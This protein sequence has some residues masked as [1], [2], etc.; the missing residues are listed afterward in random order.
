MKLS[1]ALIGC[2]LVVACVV[3]L[4]IAQT[5]GLSKGDNQTIQF[6]GTSGEKTMTTAQNQ[7]AALNQA[8]QKAYN[9]ANKRGADMMIEY[10]VDKISGRRGGFAGFNEVTVTISVPKSLFKSGGN[11]GN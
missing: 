6:T 9:Q 2:A 1:K 8:V 4:G 11:S 10:T 7:D 5:G 3:S